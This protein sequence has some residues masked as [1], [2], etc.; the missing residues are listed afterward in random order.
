MIVHLVN[1]MGLGYKVDVEV[2]L[3]SDNTPY[4]K[5]DD[6]F[7]QASKEATIYLKDNGQFHAAMMLG[8]TLKQAGVEKVNLYMPFAIGARQDRR[9][10]D[11]DILF[12]AKYYADIINSVGFDKVTIVDPHSNVIAG[13]INNRRII[14]AGD[15]L[16]KTMTPKFGSFYDGVIAPDAG[17]TNRAYEAANRLGIDR[18]YQ[19]WKHRSTTDGSI[20]GFGIEPIPNGSYLMVDDICDGGGTFIGLANILPKGVVCDLYVTHGLF[21]NGLRELKKKF[22]RIITTN[23]VPQYEWADTIIGIEDHFYV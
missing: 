8:A 3:Y 5:S 1:M 19:A 13:L 18:V 21:S 6:I 9:N 20:T 2:G 15:I 14:S 17:A 10:I 23:S 4:I 22:H 11:G 7:N 16:A 12:G